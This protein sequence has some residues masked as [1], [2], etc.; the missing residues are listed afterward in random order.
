MDGS[1]SPLTVPCSLRAAAAADRP[2][3]ESV[4]DGDLRLYAALTMFAPG[5]A[6]DPCRQG[7]EVPT[8]RSRTG[9]RKEVRCLTP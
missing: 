7:A 3:V 2:D 9:G 4:L 1:A 8:G 5:P 6:T